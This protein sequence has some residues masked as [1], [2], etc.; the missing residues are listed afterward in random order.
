MCFINSSE[1]VYLEQNEPFSTLKTLISKK[2]AFQK[3]TQFLQ[4][5]DEVDA[6]ACN[7]DGFLLRGTCL[8]SNYMN[9]PMWK[10][11]AFLQLEIY[12]LTEVS[13]HKPSSHKETMS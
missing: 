8:S 7:T 12:V 11:W 6:S 10:K 13:I 4:G 2:F 3:L 5:K 9:M 1:Y